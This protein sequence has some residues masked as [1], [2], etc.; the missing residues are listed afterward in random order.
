MRSY[1]VA[2]T[3]A[4]LSW[5]STANSAET[6]IRPGLWEVTT[7][8]NLLSLASQLPPDQLNNLNDL[9]REFGLEIPEIQNG[10]AKSNACITPEMA[11][12]KTL[13]D[14]FQNQAG[15]TIKNATQNK[16]NYRVEFVCKNAQLSGNGVA[17]GT[18]KTAESF[19]GTTIFNG[20]VQ[21]NAV[22]DQA[23]ING[24]WVGASCGTIKTSQH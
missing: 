24:K 21:G 17:E 1:L 23:N 16:N 6:A 8:S 22:S 7:T 20:S 4:S 10:A 15:C 9:A 18:F 11:N 13:P 2:L 3:L 5:A 14:A 19:S 12:Q